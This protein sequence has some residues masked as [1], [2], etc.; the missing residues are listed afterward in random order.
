[1]PQLR[2]ESRLESDQGACFIRVPP[3]VLGVLG[4]GTRTPVKVTRQ[5]GMLRARPF[6]TL[7]GQAA[8]RW[9]SS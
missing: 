9:R 1:M 3:E 5:M 8:R 2:F 6:A 4:Q 7:T